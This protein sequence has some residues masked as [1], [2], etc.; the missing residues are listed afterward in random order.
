MS[1]NLDRNVSRRGFLA[2]SGGT[3]AAVPFLSPLSLAATT[4]DRVVVLVELAGGNDGLNTVIPF[5]DD[6][7][8]RLRP[9]L[10]VGKGQVLTLD[11][12]LGFHPALSELH[13]LYEDG[14]VAVLNNV[15]Y[16]QPDR[17]HFRSMDIWHSA[18]TDAETPDTG[19]LGR[20]A[21]ALAQERPGIAPALAVGVRD[22]PLALVGES[23][24]AP[25]IRSADEFR[26]D[27]GD[28][29]AADRRM[30]RLNALVANPT[31]SDRLSFLRATARSTYQTVD[32][33]RDAAASGS[34][35]VEYPGSDLA[36]ALRDVASWI[37]AGLSSRVYFVR[38]GGFDTHAA[39]GELHQQLLRQLSAALGAFQQ[40]LTARGIGK[41][42]A[43][44]VYSE[45]GRR[46]K[47]N[48]SRGTDH[49][50][51]APS[52]VI[53][54]SVRGGL[55]GATPDLGDLVEGD[56]RYSIDFRSIYSTLLKD[57]MHTDARAVLGGRFDS[58]DLFRRRRS[59]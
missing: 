19:W 26:V 24:T 28:G 40:D 17:S 46:V 44:L 55:H 27:V 11:D 53:G 45:F 48:A 33:L 52:F 8:H 29:P 43:T 22:V 49:G 58:L 57:W 30:Q 13:E 4:T 14:R 36:R 5:E 16:P 18:S 32:K 37:G 2:T 50:A 3:L 25:A 47:E 20:L 51:A 10:R 39:Q 6:R 7:Y 9:T 41:R 1:S 42:V 15:G 35:G 59:L 54:Q 12:Q 31:S 38:L 21:D 56:L 34:G 23:V